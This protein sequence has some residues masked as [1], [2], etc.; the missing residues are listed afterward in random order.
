[1]EFSDES[2]ARAQNSIVRTR[3]VIVVV[4]TCKVRAHVRLVEYC[5]GL[6]WEYHD[7][8]LWS[9]AAPENMRWSAIRLTH[10]SVLVLPGLNAVDNVYPVI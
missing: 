8:Q 6:R 10:A 4:Y 5:V 1:M 9:R 3:C 2:C 7:R